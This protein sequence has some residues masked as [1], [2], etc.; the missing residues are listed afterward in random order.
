MRRQAQNK[1]IFL[2]E[3]KINLDTSSCFPLQAKARVYR[4]S[5]ESSAGLIG[6]GW[7]TLIGHSPFMPKVSPK[8]ESSLFSL[9]L[10]IARGQ[11]PSGIWHS[12]SECRCKGSAYDNQV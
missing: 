6:R 8:T 5:T 12:Q 2:A 9:A 7:A 11:F 10:F 3:R 1:N 4:R